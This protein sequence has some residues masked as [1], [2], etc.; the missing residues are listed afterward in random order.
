MAVV[1]ARGCF[2]FDV[3]FII[4]CAG[5]TVIFIFIF[6][7]RF[8]FVVGGVAMMPRK[9]PFFRRGAQVDV[10]IYKR[11]IMYIMYSF[12]CWGS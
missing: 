4:V 5:V 9:S 7:F 6:L 10:R 3:L 1:W 2:S 11:R 12:V 8:Y